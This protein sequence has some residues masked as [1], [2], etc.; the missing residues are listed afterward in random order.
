MQPLAVVPRS[1]RLPCGPWETLRTSFKSS[2][3][4]DAAQAQEAMPNHYKFAAPAGTL[5]MFE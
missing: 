3:T 2:M 4:L 1:F 5:L